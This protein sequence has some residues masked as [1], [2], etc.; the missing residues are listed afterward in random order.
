MRYEP[1]LGLGVWHAY[2]PDGRS[3]DLQ[4]VTTPET[5]ALIRSHHC[6]V[7]D[8]P[9]GIQI[10]TAVTDSTRPKIPLHGDTVLRFHLVMK[11]Q[12]FALFT[13]LSAFEGT[14]A[15][16]YRNDSA[17]AAVETLGL[18]S[19]IVRESEFHSV[20]A[21]SDAETYRLAGR[22]AAGAEGADFEAVASSGRLPVRAYDPAQRALTVNTLSTKP[23][24]S[25]EVTYPVV[26][27]RPAN[28]FAAVDLAG[29]GTMPEWTGRPV[30]FRIQFQAL[31]RHWLYYVITG[32]ENGHLDFRVEEANPTPSQ[33]RIE[34]NRV[35][36]GPL[37][38][39]FGP[40]PDVSRT[41][42]RQF[43][44]SYAAAFVSD[45]PI[46]C[47]LTARKNIKLTVEGR[48]LTQHL[49]SPSP[50]TATT[51]LMNDEGPPTRT[52]LYEVI[53]LSR[54]SSPTPV[55]R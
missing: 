18:V 9:N 11:N 32:S 19:E 23:G 54:T 48:T 6:V 35:A 29:H 1:L 46:P 24:D 40:A 4:V 33:P 41:L 37:D 38:D 28:V 8:R 25:V 52:A 47:R 55:G 34:F 22:P 17:P 36:A 7:K 39:N 50:R 27:R 10:F 20:R 3:S 42:T 13:D 43:P 16:L 31:S 5:D 51:I 49:A 30:D 15:P 45:K 21:D 2:Y 12:G 14:A 53:N 44:D 26:P